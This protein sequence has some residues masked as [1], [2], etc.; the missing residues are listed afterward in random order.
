MG[1]TVPSFR[2]VLAIE[3]E[4]WKPYRN[5]LSKSDKK[6]FDEMWDIPRLYILACSNSC[7]L[8]PLQPIMI[9]IIFH[10]YKELKEY[11]AEAQLMIERR[12]NMKE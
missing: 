7:Q 9:S 6:H 1:R 10:H 2:S 5:A 4:E 11:M 8:V 3:K 12:R